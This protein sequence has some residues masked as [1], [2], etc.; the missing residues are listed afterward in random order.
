[1]GFWLFEDFEITS[2]FKFINVRHPLARLE[3]CW[4]DKFTFHGIATHDGPINWY[5]L[6]WRECNKH[7]N[8]DTLAAKPKNQKCSFVAFLKFITQGKGLTSM[9]DKHWTPISWTCSAC[10][11]KYDMITKIETVDSDFSQ[12]LEK[13]DLSDSL[14]NFEKA[15]NASHFKDETRAENLQQRYQNYIKK[16]QNLYKSIPKSTILDLYKIYFWDFKLFGYDILPFL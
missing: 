7:E 10:L 1:M 2:A 5:K 4:R 12:F 16:L 8:K 14:G 3:S 9:K 13:M 11:V 6:H 15:Y